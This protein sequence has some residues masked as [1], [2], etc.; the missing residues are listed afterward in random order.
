MDPITQGALGAALPQSIKAKWCKGGKYHVALA[1][2]FGML[3]GIAADLD[4]LI[5]SDAD[6]LLF[7]NFHRQFTH[8]LIFIPFGGLIV[9]SFVQLF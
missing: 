7:L 3:G 2:L 8:S 1:G 4:V 9:A 6:P 5:Y